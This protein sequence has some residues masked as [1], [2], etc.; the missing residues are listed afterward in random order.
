MENTNA[1]APSP[2][3]IGVQNGS[4]TGSPPE[5][6]ARP[7]ARKFREMRY[8]VRFVA[9]IF[10]GPD[11][12]G[13]VI[14]CISRS[15]GVIDELSKVFPKGPATIS[16]GSDTFT[17]EVIRAGRT[18]AAFKFDQNLTRRE[19]LMFRDKPLRPSGRAKPLQSAGHH[20]Y[21]EM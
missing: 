11:R 17:V 18:K 3:D 7:V 9:D 2:R 12:Y 16:A 21:R 8:R 5:R 19:L 6:K 13:G 1:A 14:T 15:G 20:G 4:D 10:S